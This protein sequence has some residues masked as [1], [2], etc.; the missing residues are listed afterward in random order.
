VQT[1][2][3]SDSHVADE[4]TN[5][6]DRTGDFVSKSLG[7]GTRRRQARAVVDVRVA[8]AGCTD[9]NPGICWSNYGDRDLLELK[10]LA[11]CDQPDSLHVVSSL[12]LVP[13]C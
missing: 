3:V 2:S 9:T 4:R 1:N 8:D 10:G 11:Y 7:K 12:Y 5:L 6:F 13:K